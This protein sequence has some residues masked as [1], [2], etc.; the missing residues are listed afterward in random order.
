MIKGKTTK[1]AVLYEKASLKSKV[2]DELEPG[3]PLT[4]KGYCY[5][6]KEAVELAHVIALPKGPRDEKQDGW[7]RSSEV[8]EDRSKPAPKPK[9]VPPMFEDRLFRA[10]EWK[11]AGIAVAIMAAVILACLLYAN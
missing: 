8:V 11:A 5:V 2:K 9:P 4:I 6:E 7:V 10:A 3:Y 1:S